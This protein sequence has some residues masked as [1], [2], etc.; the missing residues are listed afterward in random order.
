MFFEDPALLFGA[1]L[2]VLGVLGVVVAI[3]SAVRY[4]VKPS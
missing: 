1:P 4:W 3:G 2:L